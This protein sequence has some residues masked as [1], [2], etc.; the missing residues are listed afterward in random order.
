VIAIVR[1][2][3]WIYVVLLSTLCSCGDTRLPPGIGAGTASSSPS[4]VSA[5]GAANDACATAS[6]GHGASLAVCPGHGRIGSA[7]TLDGVMCNSPSTTAIIYFG[8]P[9][10]NDSGPSLIAPGSVEVGRFSVD[11]ANRFGARFQIPSDLQ[12]I[13]GTGGGA[14]TPGKYAFY[15]KPVVCWTAF[16]GDP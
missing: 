11:A 1:H 12:G 10:S 5:S 15:S 13:Q 6:D 8:G 14:V 7:V 2:V 9:L 3:R 4:I 16:V